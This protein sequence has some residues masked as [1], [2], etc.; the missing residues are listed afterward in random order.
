MH[1]LGT[2]L[3]VELKDCNSK[4]LNDVKKI[5]DIL[6]TAAKEAKATIIESRFH[7]FSP[8]GISGVVVIAESHLT[9][10]TW[11]EY[12]YAAVDIFTCGE[13]LQP[14]VAASYI[15]A[16]LQSKNPS[17]V[18]MKRGLLSLGDQKLPHKPVKGEP[19]HYDRAKELQMVP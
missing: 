1:A 8:F 3:L 11:P 17:L 14:S 13:T 4:I 15:V 10:H 19:V 5:E 9:I 12:G 7:K 18:E 6:V 2:H 16:K